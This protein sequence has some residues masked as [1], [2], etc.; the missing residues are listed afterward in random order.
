M[1]MTNAN[2]ALLM[3]LA[4]AQAEIENATKGS[5]NPAFRSK[6]ADLAE[7]LNTCRPVLAKHGMCIM[8]STSFDGATVSVQTV[9]GHKEGGWVSSCAS[10]VP[11]KVDAQGIGAATTYL[12]RY[13]LAAMVAIAQEDDDGNSAQHAGRPAPVTSRKPDPERYVDARQALRDAGSLSELGAVWRDLS[14]DARKALAEEKDSA[15]TRLSASQAA[16]EV[17]E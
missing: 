5:V 7:V 15:K 6:Y 9:L 3:A 13:S 12:R 1:D 17:A 14:A 4:A 2:P 11:A 10:C 8:Q 16:Q